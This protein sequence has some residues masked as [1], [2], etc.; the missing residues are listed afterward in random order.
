MRSVPT[1]DDPLSMNVVVQLPIP[2]SL[3]TV[4]LTPTVLEFLNDHP[5]A[6]K[7]SDNSPDSFAPD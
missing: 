2:T 5:G 6:A 1:F 3:S 7:A 4:S